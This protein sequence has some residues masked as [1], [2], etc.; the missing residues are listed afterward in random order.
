MKILEIKLRRKSVCGILFDEQVDP[1]EWEADSDAAG[2]LSLDAELCEMK[3]LKAGMDLTP[4]ELA[5]LIEESHIK[6]AKSRALWYISRG[7]CPKNALTKKLCKSFPEYAAIAATERMVELGLVNDR[8]YAERRLQL[9]IEGKKVSLKMAKQMLLLEGI[10]REIVDEVAECTE[11]D[12]SDTIK[13]LIERKYKEKLNCQK[14]FERM[15]AALLR[16][17][18]SYGEIK[19]A[20]REL[21]IE[22]NFSE[23]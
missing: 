13:C 7:D 9:I 8:A 5:G 3:H 12:N 20:L 1:K 16:K 14:D 23:D 10:D 6:R 19:D 15:M 21:E 11:C 22:I 2:W 4:D 18:Y 17:G